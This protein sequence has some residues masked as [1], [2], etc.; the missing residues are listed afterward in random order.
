MVVA[1]GAAQTCTKRKLEGKVAHVY[2]G[3][4]FIVIRPRAV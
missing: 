1:L 3:Y 2:I 4:V